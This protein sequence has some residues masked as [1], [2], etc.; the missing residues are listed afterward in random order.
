MFSGVD[1]AVAE[2][3]LCHI[4][5]CIVLN[6][7]GGIV[8]GCSRDPQIAY[9]YRCRLSFLPDLH[10]NHHNQCAEARPLIYAGVKPSRGKQTNSNSSLL[11]LLLLL[12]LPRVDFHSFPPTFRFTTSPPLKQS[13]FPGFSVL[14]SPSS[15]SF[16]SHT[17][18]FIGST[19]SSSDF[20]YFHRIYE[21]L[22]ESSILSRSRSI[23]TPILSL[24]SY[25]SLSRE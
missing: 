24:T 23:T 20:R 19:I 13:N 15:I 7:S 12:L 17:R 6:H 9:S 18:L 22:I 4:P 10:I 2:S 11:L 25:S 8:Q 5:G 16:Q 3:Q 21:F 1:G 14:S